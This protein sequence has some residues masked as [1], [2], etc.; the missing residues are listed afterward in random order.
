MRYEAKL[1]KILI[2]ILKQVFKEYI[3]NLILAKN[4]LLHI[5]IRQEFLLKLELLLNNNRRQQN[6]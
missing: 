1:V 4:L 2:G 6:F 5:S 3:C